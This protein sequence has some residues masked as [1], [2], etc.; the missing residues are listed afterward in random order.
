VWDTGIIQHAGM[1]REEYAHHEEELVRAEKLDDVAGGTPE[2]WAYD[3][4][5][6]AQAAWA[7]DGT[8]LDEGYYQREIKVVDRQMALA[9]LRLAKVLNAT[10]GKMTPR[11]FAAAAPGTAAASMSTSREDMPRNTS[12]QNDE[13]TVKVWVNTGSG[14]YHCPT[15]QWYGNTKRGEY[16]TQAD[17]QKKGYRP[18]NGRTCQ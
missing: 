18:A 9:G 16:L 14:V 3:S 10:I 7:Q 6:L 15:T 2:Q 4:L 11:Y 12:V 1:Q 5:R 17:A 8:D 13:S